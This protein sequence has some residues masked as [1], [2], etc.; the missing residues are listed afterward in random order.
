LADD[1]GTS[2]MHL[3][4]FLTAGTFKSGIGESRRSLHVKIS[5]EAS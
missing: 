5:L 2:R 1:F 3:Q 4:A